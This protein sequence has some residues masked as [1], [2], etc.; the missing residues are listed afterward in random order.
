MNYN[1]AL[2]NGAGGPDEISDQQFKGLLLK[3]QQKGFDGMSLEEVATAL[4]LP[5][6]AKTFNQHTGL[7]WTS[8]FE[9]KAIDRLNRSKF[10]IQWMARKDNA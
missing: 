5:N 1:K 10:D 3:F 9:V 8:K 2:D 7:D 4:I 6:F